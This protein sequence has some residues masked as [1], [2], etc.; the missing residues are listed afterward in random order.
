[1]LS[2]RFWSFKKDSESERQTSHNT[3]YAAAP[4]FD[5]LVTRYV[6]DFKMSGNYSASFAYIPFLVPLVPLL[7]S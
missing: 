1:M 2:N 7:P 4:D 3:A 6:L 5:E